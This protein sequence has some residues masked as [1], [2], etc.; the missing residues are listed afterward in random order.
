MF[1]Q[2]GH[3]V[4]INLLI[5]LYIHLQLSVKDFRQMLKNSIETE[6]DPVMCPCPRSLQQLYW[7]AVLE[8]LPTGWRR[9][10]FFCL[11]TGDVTP[12]ATG[13]VPGTPEHRVMKMV[14]EE[15]L[16]ELRLLPKEGQAQDDF[17]ILYKCLKIYCRKWARLFPLMPGDKMRANGHKM[18]HRM[19]HLNIRK[20]PFNSKDGQTLK[21]F[22][23]E[24]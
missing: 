20:Q 15:K 16:R 2:R 1:I 24:R 13:P 11:S 22:S 23:P 8:V 4:K 6:R 5:A 3:C 19:F 12:A 14:N 9:W 10:S 18:K 21:L 17:F 7:E